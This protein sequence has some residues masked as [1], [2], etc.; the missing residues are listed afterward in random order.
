MLK[1]LLKKVNSA[2]KGL[3][4]D[5]TGSSLIMVIVAVGF[6]TILS[7]VV[8]SSAMVNYKVRAIDRR[9]KDAFYY[10]EVAL[11]D[12]YNAVGK[13]CELATLRAYKE[14]ATDGGKNSSYV[15]SENETEESIRNK[16]KT[17]F[18]TQLGTIVG[19]Y[20][21]A[22]SDGNSKVLKSYVK[23]VSTNG[24]SGDAFVITN[25]SVESVTNS[26]VKSLKVTCKESATGYISTISTDIVFDVPDV[27]LKMEPNL[28]LDYAIVAN[29]GIIIE[30]DATLDVTGRVYA[31]S[32]AGSSQAIT[33]GN[34]D[35]VDFKSEY[36]VARGDIVI[37]DSV[38]GSNVTFDGVNDKNGVKKTSYVWF[39][40][41]KINNDNNNIY[42]KNNTKM[43]ALGDLELNGNGNNIVFEGDGNTSGYYGYNNEVLVSKSEAK[44]YKQANSGHAQS[45]SIIFNGN[46]N[47]I[48]GKLK[49]L[50]IMGRAYLTGLSSTLPE[51]GT[52]EGI[53]YK[54]GQEIYL[55]PTE[56]LPDGTNSNPASSKNGTT[57]N[58]PSDWEG[59]SFLNSNSIKYGEKSGAYYYFLDIKDSEV[60]KYY[61]WIKGQSVTGSEPTA[62]TLYQRITAS[63]NSSGN[64]FNVAASNDY[65]HNN[66]FSIES[67][68]GYGSIADVNNNVFVRYQDICTHLWPYEEISDFTT[69]IDTGIRK[70]QGDE[71][72]NIDTNGLPV[73][74]Y[75]SLTGDVRD[76]FN[77]IDASS[78]P[79]ELKS[80]YDCDK[81]P[82]KVYLYVDGD[83]E[84]SGNSPLSGYNGMIFATGTVTVKNGANV[85][86]NNDKSDIQEN[87]DDTFPAY[88]DYVRYENWKKGR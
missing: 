23:N 54:S 76:I 4:N 71:W 61:N 3:L 13:D 53:A 77:E 69:S 36:L 78:T 22:D 10:A 32:E 31:G 28:L 38:G 42:V 20:S 68:T 26:K 80:D 44:E 25:I 34:N 60:V 6:V 88:S 52:G 14:V 56:F 87:R 55:C 64:Q 79:F 39:E 46:R 62:K 50:M 17:E 74:K 8:A 24:S 63:N 35:T 29:K 66:P 59:S 40:N 16:F 47:K 81:H 86:I 45:S 48:D 84:I 21:E 11:D 18:E 5:N 57:Y 43:F 49:E 12:I 58:I 75:G 82:G 83:I 15:F 30:A 33:I 72:N 41:Y 2:F 37:N 70:T 73:S 85:V 9:T 19:K 51:Y 65:Y 27:P 1:E 7:G 67:S